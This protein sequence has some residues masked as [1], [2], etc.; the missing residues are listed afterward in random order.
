MPPKCP[1]FRGFTIIHTHR[2]REREVH[3]EVAD[4]RNMVVNP[5]LGRLYV[6]PHYESPTRHL[7]FET[8][9]VCVSTSEDLECYR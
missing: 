3:C 1:L 8:M 5:L 6:T 7:E 9:C 4:F 2:E